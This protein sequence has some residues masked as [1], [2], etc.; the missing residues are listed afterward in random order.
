MNFRKTRQFDDASGEQRFRAIGVSPAIMMEG[1]R[2]L[3]DAL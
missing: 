1:R 2:D 3:N